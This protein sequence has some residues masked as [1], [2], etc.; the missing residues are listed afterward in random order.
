MSDNRTRVR[1]QRRTQ[2][3]RR[4]DIDVAGI[5]QDK[6]RAVPAYWLEAGTIGRV[7]LG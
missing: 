2:V 4:R 6:V 7:T 5:P 3:A 1:L